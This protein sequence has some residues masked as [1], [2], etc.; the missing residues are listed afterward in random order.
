LDEDRHLK[1][2]E[3]N[4]EP[5][6]YEQRGFVPVRPPNRD[7]KTPLIIEPSAPAPSGDRPASGK[8]TGDKAK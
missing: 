4:I 8:G 3:K 5:A 6:D 1:K 2:I 7:P